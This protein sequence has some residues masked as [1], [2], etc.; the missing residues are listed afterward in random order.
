MKKAAL[1][2]GKEPSTREVAHLVSLMFVMGRHIKE[3]FQ[4]LA[5]QASCSFLDFQTL[6]YIEEKKNPSMREV[7]AH[8]MITPP[9]ATLMIDGLVKEKLIS[10]APD[11]K[12][13]RTVR[14]RV[15]P[16]GDALLEKSTHQA[17]LALARLFKDLSPGERAELVSLLKKVVKEK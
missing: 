2:R 15:T 1:G 16:K 6:R 5:R 7:A 17:T 12:D 4:N 13:R 3:Q 8:F 14:L 9:A 11:A 10:R